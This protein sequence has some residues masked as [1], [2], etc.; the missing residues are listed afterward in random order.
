MTV[1]PLNRRTVF[2]ANSSHWP[3]STRRPA[4]SASHGLSSDGYARAAIPKAI[5]ATIRPAAS[6]AAVMTAT[7]MRARRDAGIRAASGA[8]I[9]RRRN[10]ATKTLVGWVQSA[11]GN[12]T[13]AA[14]S[15]RPAAPPS[16]TPSSARYTTRPDQNTDCDGS[17][18]IRLCAMAVGR[19]ASATVWIQAVVSP[20][21]RRPKPNAATS[22]STLARTGTS[23]SS[24]N[25]G[26]AIAC[27]S[28]TGTRKNRSIGLPLVVR[29]S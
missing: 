24:A 10:G 14:A 18:Q 16:F 4:A 12:R 11:T 2:T 23:R 27:R 25:D 5:H 17:W 3:A 21:S 26:D 1:M 9:G 19:T 29:G 22:A 6:T 28:A 20:N 8:A 15:Q 13:I 7:P